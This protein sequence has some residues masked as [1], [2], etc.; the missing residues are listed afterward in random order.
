M[1]RFLSPAL[2]TALLVAGAAL[3]ADAPAK[4]E[5][6]PAPALVIKPVNGDGQ[7]YDVVKEAEGDCAVLFVH[8]GKLHAHG[9]KAL[10][11]AFSHHYD[12]LSTE[13]WAPDLAIVALAAPDK[14]DALNESLKAFAER[15]GLECPLAALSADAV[16]DWHVPAD[17][18]A[19]VCWVDE[20]KL[21][22]TSTEADEVDD[23]LL[24][25]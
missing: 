19:V 7:P 18:D 20:G 6:T 22:G 12:E 5:E 17:G 2:L 14:I 3:A 11:D 21:A 25:N 1:K 24:D 16:K 8:E 13:E 9:T 15:L 4:D 23:V 10:I